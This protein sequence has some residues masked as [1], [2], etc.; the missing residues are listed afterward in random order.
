MPW[1]IA[2]VSMIATT[3]AADT[4][5]AVTELV[6]QSGIAGNWVWWNMLIGGMFTVFFFSR[7]WR[8]ADV[9]T[10]VELISIR[11]SGTKA[12]FLRL[13]KSVYLGLFLNVLVI[14]WVNQ[15]FLSISE[16]F[17]GVKGISAYFLLIGAM[18]F[19]AFYSALAGLKGVAITD[20]IQFTLAMLGCIILAVV[21]VDSDMVGG[22]SGLKE[23]LPK[24]SLNFFPKISNSSNSGTNL[25]LN[26][27]KFI[28]FM[29][30][31]WWASWY[32]GN[33]PGG[34]GY[35]AQR[36]MSAKN[37][38]HSFFATLFFQ[39][40]NY[41]LR[42]WPWIITGLT[43]IIVYPNLSPETQKL[44]FLYAINDFLPVGLKGLMI[45]AML[46]AYM[47]TIS[48]Q[49]N[50]GASYL[51]NDF[52]LQLKKTK[53]TDKQLVSS[54]RVAT[55]IIMIIATIVTSLFNSISEVWVFVLECGAGLGL[56]LILRWFWWRINAWS[57]IV[58]SIVPFLSFAF[59]RIGGNLELFEKIEFPESFF[60][61]VFITTFSWLLI[62]FLTKPTDEKQL[63]EF[64]KKIEPNGIWRKISK[65]IQ[66]SEKNKFPKQS[67]L[68]SVIGWL[69]AVFFTYSLLLGIGNIIL[70]NWQE[71]L[72]YFGITVFTSPFLLVSVNKIFSGKK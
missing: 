71:T 31:I 42:P 25:S 14:S 40:S 43:V 62:T 21:V 6:A 4:P 24:E 38:K 20:I 26:W 27:H 22:I 66:A 44:G 16:V 63:I 45:V 39:T 29:G 32:P 9:L 1:Y 53:S 64:Y 59:F 56:V 13:F 35:I 28:A 68:W 12:R 47:S 67:V 33:E 10:E 72:V 46:A 65:E 3:F 2:G 17:F 48:T 23:K 11:Y 15:A 57:E 30:F 51:V 5:L 69:S 19:T 41:A 49:L 7:L 52:Y 61:T 70:Q 8:R 36:M 37:E 50:W 18:L 54:A 58:A 60:Y 34:G 55:F